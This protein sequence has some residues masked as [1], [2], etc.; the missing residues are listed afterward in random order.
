VDERD[1]GVGAVEA[2]AAVVDQADSCVECFEAAVGE[3][4]LDRGQDAV[5]VFA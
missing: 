3:A 2:V 5:A 4:E 1:Q